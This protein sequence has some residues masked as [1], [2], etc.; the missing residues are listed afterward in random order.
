M[1]SRSRVSTVFFLSA[2]VQEALVDLFELLLVQRIAQLGQPVAQPSPAR[3]RRE[4]DLRVGH[5][6][7]AGI[8]DLVGGALLEH[9]VLVDAGRVGKG[10]GSHDGLVGLHRD[11]GQLADQPAD[12][13]DAPGIDAGLQLK[14]IVGGS[15]A[16]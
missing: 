15:G 6:H 5:A 3:S 13:I 8:D 1:A 4:H 2:T 12:G 14:E 10:V 7:V 9:A 11:A 16:P